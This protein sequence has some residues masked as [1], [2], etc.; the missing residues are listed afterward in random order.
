M[1]SN[2]GLGVDWTSDYIYYADYSNGQIWMTRN[3]GAYQKLVLSDL[4][5]PQ[6]LTLEMTNRWLWNLHRG[7]GEV[8]L[9]LIS[10]LHF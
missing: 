2:L 10:F 6:A 8:I 5:Q 3:D 1:I 9:H 4:D 7:Q